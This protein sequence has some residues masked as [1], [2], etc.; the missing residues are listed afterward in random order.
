MP[1]YSKQCL[2]EVREEMHAL[3]TAEEIEDIF[4]CLQ[5]FKKLFTFE[6]IKNVLKQCSPRALLLQIH[7]KF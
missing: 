5:G 1:A 7:S 6:E 4:N 3:Y 2:I